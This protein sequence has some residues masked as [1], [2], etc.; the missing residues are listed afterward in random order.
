MKKNLI[1]IILLAVIL[2]AGYFKFENIQM[3]RR[4]MNIEFERLKPIHDSIDTVN[5]DV[6]I[7]MEI[8]EKKKEELRILETELQKD[9]YKDGIGI[10]DALRIFGVK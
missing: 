10:E 4:L 6:V 3:K 5:G 7:S 8:I 2:A 9:E 1:N